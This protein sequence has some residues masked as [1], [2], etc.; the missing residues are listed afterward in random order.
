MAKQIFTRAGAMVFSLL[1][2]LLIPVFLY[3]LL[4]DFP[5]FR[6]P[7]LELFPVRYQGF[8]DSRLGRVDRV[9]SGFVRG[10][11]VVS[12]I[13]A[14]VSNIIPYVGQLFGATLSLLM[15]LVD[16][17][18]WGRVI[19]VPIFFMVTNFLEGQFLTPKIVGDKVGLSIPQAILA[20][21]IGA[22]L[23]GIAGMILALPA[24]GSIKVLFP[25]F[26]KLYRQS[27]FYRCRA[28][29]GHGTSA[30]KSA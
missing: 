27:A 10:Q 21:L 3:F 7:F 12:G 30:R 22:K 24:A 11:L 18:G 2:L 5:S 23:A 19:A 1:E 4:K 13:L 28:Y 15:I 25:D 9:C 14:G 29:P 8:V 26:L 6:K 17:P 20:L 16:F